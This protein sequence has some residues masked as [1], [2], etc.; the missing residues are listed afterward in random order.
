MRFVSASAALAA[1]AIASGA[2]PAAAAMD[3]FKG[4][5]IMSYSSS[6][7]GGGFD[8][9][10]RLLA[11]HI[12]R[13]IPETPTIVAGNRL[14]AGGL[15]FANWLY[16]KAPKDGTTMGIVPAYILLERLYGNKKALF[17]PFR[18]IWLGNMNQEVDHCSVWHSTG[19][20]KPEDFFTR[21]VILGASGASAGSFTVPTIMNAVMGT[22]FRPI[23]GYRSGGKRVMA[24]EQG[25]IQGQC[26]TYLSSVK[27]GLIQKVR[28]GQ[29]KIIWQMGFTPH[30]DFRD[31]PLAIDYAKTEKAKRV[32]TMFFATMAIGRASALPPDVPADR[33]KMLRAAY[34]ATMRDK[35]FLAEAKKARIEIRSMSADGMNPYLKRL[36]GHPREIYAEAATI[37]KRGRSSAKKLK[38]K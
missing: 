34:D 25:E 16:N 38:K 33:V 24:M 7:V 26:G 22:K 5:R 6:R 30:P 15:V 29:L 23:L 12:G 32:L 21:E 28:S 17:N 36:L 31:V 2:P 8:I 10:N 18:F 35:L 37:L 14:G 4:K 1:I 9:Y 20:T 13:H 3:A 19:I 11:R 27:A